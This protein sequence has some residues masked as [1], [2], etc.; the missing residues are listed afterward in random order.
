MAVPASTPESLAAWR[1]TLYEG[2]PL[3]AATAR[4][5]MDEVE[6][7]QAELARARVDFATK[8]AAALEKR[9]ADVAAFNQGGCRTCRDAEAR[10]FLAKLKKVAGGG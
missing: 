8:A 10:A 7:L 9:L 3:D 4:R 5:L 6:Q 1:K 2:D